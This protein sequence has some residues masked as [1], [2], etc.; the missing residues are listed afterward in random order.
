MSGL[1]ARHR[2]AWSDRFRVPEAHSLVGELP[3]AFGPAVEHARR[4]LTGTHAFTESVCWQGVWNW[5]L[6]YGPNPMPPIAC[7]YVVPDPAKP[8]LCIPFP[9]FTLRAMSPKRVG[10][11]V[12]DT[13]VHAPSVNGIRWATWDIQSKAQVEEVLDLVTLGLTVQP[14]MAAAT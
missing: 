12:R 10:K 9:E 4:I 13:L 3:R 6:R 11:S 5:C 8:R 1:A 7:A 2:P 14:P